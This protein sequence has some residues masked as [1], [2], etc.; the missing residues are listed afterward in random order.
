MSFRV[1]GCATIFCVGL[2]SIGV[3]GGFSR[4][5]FRFR[6]FVSAH[7]VPTGSLCEVLGAC[8]FGLSFLYSQS[9]GWGGRARTTSRI[10]SMSGI[11]RS[12]LLG[13]CRCDLAYKLGSCGLG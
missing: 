1:H 13:P 9:C 2:A 8:G 4:V 10:E 5:E 3:L 7:K 11:I 12:N 6:A